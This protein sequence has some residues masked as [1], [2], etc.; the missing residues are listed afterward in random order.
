MRVLIIL[1]ILSLFLLACEQEEQVILP[2]IEDVFSQDIQIIDLEDSENNL[3]DVTTDVTNET[4]NVD[5]SEETDS[6]EET[7][8]TT[9]EQEIAFTIEFEEGD[10]INLKEI[11]SDP[12][13]DSLNLQFSEPLDEEGKWQTSIGDAGIYVVT[14]IASD[15]EFSVE[16]NI[17]LTILSINK[18]PEIQALS[19]ITINEGETLILEYKVTD[20]EN[21][22]F[23]TTIKGYTKE[24]EK[25]INYNQAFPEGCEE[26]GCTAEYTITIE[27]E[28][29]FQTTTHEIKLLVNDVNRL[30]EIEAEDFEA[31]EGEVVTLNYEVTDKDEDELTITIEGIEEE[32]QTEVGDAGTYEIT[33]TAT[34]GVEQTTKT[35]NLEVKAL[36]NLPE[37]EAPEEVEVIE[38]DLVSIDVTATDADQD[39][40]IIS[41]EGWMDSSTKQTTL[42]DAHPQGC[43]EEGCTA[44]Y[45]VKI[46][47]TDGKDTAEKTVLVKIQ[48]KPSTIIMGEATLQPEEPT[49]NTDLT[50]NINYADEGNLSGS[51]H[52]EWFVNG[53]FVNEEVT[54]VN[55][56]ETISNSLESTNYEKEDTVEVRIWA[57]NE[58]FTSQIQSLEVVI[59]NS[60][61]VWNFP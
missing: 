2:T 22:S 44:E 38:G 58:L 21:D 50:A 40:I 60:P 49:T 10:L 54:E 1:T 53:N 26:K 59:Q 46:L 56:G 37:I 32:W 3:T 5:S 20:A 31:T 29:D 34:D 18:A 47:A 36:N 9:E 12:D 25:E 35:I 51:I 24:K 41:F 42:E 43:T 61:P 55:S 19:E 14:I 48:D 15:G 52:F 8:E 33:I 17:Q 4:V 11:V 28:D 27:A 30:P 13:G 16:E 6:T 23:T 39:D 7:P 57:E 45:E